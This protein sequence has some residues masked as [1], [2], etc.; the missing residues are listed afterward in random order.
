MVMVVALK[1]LDGGAAPAIGSQ[2]DRLVV[3]STPASGGIRGA[4]VTVPSDS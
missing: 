1:H 4:I 3:N 2:E